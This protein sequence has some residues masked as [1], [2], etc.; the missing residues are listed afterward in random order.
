MR[1]PEEDL[2]KTK[3]EKQVDEI[4]D[5]QWSEITYSTRC[6]RRTLKLAVLDGYGLGLEAARK[7][8]K[9]EG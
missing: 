7:I 1:T 5:S 2:M 6:A 4:V 3:L 9:G 8:N